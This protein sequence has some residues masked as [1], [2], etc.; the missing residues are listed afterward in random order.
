MTVGPHVENEPPAGS[1]A[2]NQGQAA[3]RPDQPARKR[4]IIYIDGFNLYYGAIKGGP[5]KWLNLELFFRRLRPHDDIQAIRYFTAMVNGPSQTKQRTYLQAL[6]TLPSVS[7]V[8]GKYKTKHIKCTVPTCLHPGP[9]VFVSQEEK[10]TDVNIAVSMLDDVTQG[11]CERMIVVSGDSD[12]VPA[13]A[14]VKVRKPATEI[15]VYIPARN[16]TRGAAVELRSEADKDRTLPLNLLPLSQFPAVVP[17]G[18][19]GVINKPVG[20]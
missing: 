15:I 20:W 17:D 16:A 3:I 6:A 19:G 1:T 14:R 10:R 8:L 4:S 5:N 7:I 9:R 12:L 11:L 13:L 2:R 18:R